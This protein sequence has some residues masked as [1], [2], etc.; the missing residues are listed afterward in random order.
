MQT[1]AKL[2]SL[3]SL[4]PTGKIQSRI[5]ILIMTTNVFRTKALFILPQIYLLQLL[6]S[7]DEARLLIL[8][9]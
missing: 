2:G 5:I 1:Y 9:L 3:L 8:S 6:F 7:Y 4:H